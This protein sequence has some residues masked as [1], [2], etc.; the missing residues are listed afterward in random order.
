MAGVIR[1][2]PSNG[3]EQHHN[4][5]RRLNWPSAD[6]L[7]H[8][9]G[10][11]QLS[12]G[13]ICSSPQNPHPQ[14]V[15]S[16]GALASAAFR[17]A[18][19]PSKRLV[20]PWQKSLPCKLPSVRTRPSGG[21]WRSS[22][23]ALR[24]S[25]TMASGHPKSHFRK[26]QSFKTDYAPCTITQYV[27]ERS[28]MQVVVADREGPKINGYFTLATEIFDDSGAPHTLEHLI[29]M[30]SKNYRYK[31]LLDKLSSRAY[32]STNAWTATDHTAY[33]L[34]TAGWDGFAQV[35]PVYLEHIILPVITDD[36]VVT[37]VWHIDGEGNDAGVVYSEMQ[38]V[39]FRSSEIMDL[40]A[41]RLLYPEDVGFRYETGGMTEALRVLTPERIRQF[42][43]DMYQPRNLCLVIV[44]ETNHEDMLKILDEF[45][46]SIKDDIPPLTAPFKRP[47]VE[48]AQPPALKETTIT[49]A[50]FPEEDESV[51][52]IL[53]G[54]FG[55]DCTDLIATSA[56]NVLLTYL[57]GSSVS[58]LE[59]ALVEREELAS[60]I[61]HWW[62]SRP[63]SVIWLQPTGV[64]TEK[65]E[66]VEKRLFELLK[67][68]AAKPLDMEY[69]RECIRREKRQVQF[70]AETSES[71][72]AT[73][74]IT[75][76]LFGKRDGSTL[77]DLETLSEYATLEQ[78]TDEQWRDFLRKWISDAHHVSI[79]GKPSHELA[80]KMK[81][82]EADRLAKRKE[83]LGAEGLQ[84]LG[85]RL[86]EAKEKNDAPIPVEVIDRWS[87]PST[88]SIHF[89][90]SDTARCGRA[91]SV[92]LG[93]GSAQKLIDGAT[94]GNLPLFI[95]FED[96][97]TNFVHITIH[98]GTS[99][100]PVELKPLMPIFSDNFFNTHIKR[101]GKIINFEQVVMELERDSVG[102]GIGSSRSL[103][104]PD[105]FMIQFQVEPEKYVAAVNWLRTMMFDSVFDPQRLRA[106]VTKSLA[107]I[108]EGKRDGR[109]MASE[110]DAAIHMEKSSLSVAKRVLVR[111]VYLKRLKK[112]LKNEPEKVVEWFDTVRSSLFTFQNMR[113]LVTANLK[114]LA[115]PV[116]TWDPLAEALSPRQEMVP[117][118]KL[119]SL[120]NDE[121]RKPGSVG[122]IVIPMTTLD[123]S[124]S[125]SSAPSITSLSDPRFPAIMVAIGYLEA[126]EGPLWNAVRGA[127]YAYGSYFSR[128]V[129]SG[130]LSYRVYR[131]PDVSKA[132]IAS[133]DAIRNIAEGQVSI[134]KHL[135]EGTMS[136]I[137]VMFADEQSTMPSAAQQNF[138]QGVVRG[139]SSDWNKEI[140]RRVRAVTEDEMKAVMKELILPCFNPGTSNVVVTCAK[141]MAEGM[142]TAFQ[143]MGYKV[144]TR[145]L[146]YFH[147]DYG[148]EAGADDEDDEEDEDDEGSEGSDDGDS[149]ESDD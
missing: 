15:A 112:L 77:K 36:A 101:D 16:A 55:P 90:E 126:V 109:G 37:E 44:G 111:A 80:I 123:S 61:S 32:S 82:E 134:D 108:P 132:I 105:G 83:K 78:W 104:D 4:G 103:G 46:D 121:G 146:S 63:D 59:N 133:R 131:S 40:K 51:G 57:C 106:A 79:L 60:S 27:S 149:D 99:Q 74:I 28:G 11:R 84:A 140:L 50:E 58:I 23:A 125:V 6:R 10:T 89:I 48:S 118:P 56:L 115:N 142:E 29:F 91:R 39:Q 25:V 110:V 135:L 1:G 130:I 127:G 64:A 87:V 43:R 136:Q 71:F 19:S 100:V 128:S 73:N 21:H 30:G 9:W 81:N 137:V 120:L 129:D 18:S 5:W 20:V 122:A 33:T 76:Y 69:M 96:V 47:W 117:I 53:V 148:L 24:S 62:D 13:H 113:F 42:H 8:P 38:G 3:K 72:Y 7:V 85:K 144:Q 88:E 52:E 141:L 17:L 119:S 139:L 68:V 145:E 65:L 138:V 75:D 45:E 114:K 98:V 95:Q 14:K 34:E 22:L 31:G 66:F 70:H 102:Y 86:E 143:G 92:G 41:R 35:L 116:T 97:P 93:K 49:T 67:E 94:A 12:A 54:F 107:D 2:T 124:Y 26:V 147:D